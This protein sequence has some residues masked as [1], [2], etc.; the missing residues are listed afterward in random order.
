MFV[1]L[2]QFLLFEGFLERPFLEF[3]EPFLETL[4]ALLFEEG[5]EEIGRIGR[6]MGRIGVRSVRWILFLRRFLNF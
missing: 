5:E 2:G 6:R 4:Q 3:A 1:R